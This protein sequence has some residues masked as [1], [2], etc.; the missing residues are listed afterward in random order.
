MSEMLYIGRDLGLQWAGEGLVRQDFGPQALTL[1]LSAVF[2]KLTFW[3]AP[4]G[5]APEV[6]DRSQPAGANSRFYFF[7]PV[8]RGE[9]P[10][11]FLNPEYFD[12]AECH[13]SH[14]WKAQPIFPAGY[15]PGW[16]LQPEGEAELH[17][18]HP[19][20]VSFRNL[21]IVSGPESLS[22]LRVVARDIL[23]EGRAEVLEGDLLLPVLKKRARPEVR[24]WLRDGAGLLDQARLEWTARGDIRRLFFIPSPDSLDG[25]VRIPSAELL[26]GHRE[27]TLTGPEPVA[28][29]AE[30]EDGLDYTVLQ[31]TILTPQIESLRKARCMHHWFVEFMLSN[32]GHA[33]L[34]HGVGR[35]EG[36]PRLMEKNDGQ[37]YMAWGWV[38][39]PAPREEANICLTCISPQGLIS[40][41]LREDQVGDSP[42][43]NDDPDTVVL[44][45]MY[46][47]RPEE[48]RMVHVLDWSVAD[49]NFEPESFRLS[50]GDRVFTA[51]EGFEVFIE[52]E[53]RPLRFQGQNVDDRI[54]DLIIPPA[55]FNYP[56]Q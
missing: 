47:V 37:R 9:D 42:D 13:P 1:N 33:Y 14:G 49:L 21:T 53:V 2:Q 52:N 22:F 24:A 7:F 23:V 48:G 3:A 29:L 56:G 45:L 11:S 35:V 26:S 32:C 15:G 8:G 5:R 18:G 40:L 38:R 17:P 25:A 28:L 12:Q 41:E 36:T 39:L 46:T 30:H 16:L 20:L 44:N 54:F 27:F 50:A 34:N 43:S 4:D 31:P 10:A 51:A 6:E 19:A 55:E